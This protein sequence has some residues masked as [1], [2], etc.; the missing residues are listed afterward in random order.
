MTVLKT[1]LMWNIY[2]VLK[3]VLEVCSSIGICEFLYYF[4]WNMLHIIQNS[5]LNF[6][7]GWQYFASNVHR[8]LLTAPQVFSWIKFKANNLTISSNEHLWNQCHS[9]FFFMHK[10]F[11]FWKC[12]TSFE[13][14]ACKKKKKILFIYLLNKSEL[15]R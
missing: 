15:C 13:P 1:I 9:D 2:C 3:L 14:Y 8:P 5:I 7:F 6:I 12:S 4:V 11:S 10:R